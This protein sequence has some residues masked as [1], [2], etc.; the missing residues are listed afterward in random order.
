MPNRLWRVALARRRRP[1]PPW[2][3]GD[4]TTPQG[5]EEDR[6]G[7]SSRFPRRTATLVL[8]L[9]ANWCQL[10]SRWTWPWPG[11]RQTGEVGPV[12]CRGTRAGSD[13]GTSTLVCQTLA[14]S[15]DSLPATGR[16][17][18]SPAHG[19]HCLSGQRVTQALRG[20]DVKTPEPLFTFGRG[21]GVPVHSPPVEHV[22]G[23]LSPPSQP[24][25]YPTWWLGTLA[26]VVQT[27][28]EA[29]HGPETVGGLS[30]SS[31]LRKTGRSLHTTNP[32]PPLLTP[33]AGQFLGLKRPVVVNTHL[34]RSG[35][36]TAAGA[37]CPSERAGPPGG[38]RR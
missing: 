10:Q 31:R 1:E 27:W 21:H 5:V 11:C 38:G 18:K 29:A 32:P 17:A 9:W 28:N 24:A 6:R 2:K 20:P 33:H 3:F 13:L 4:H 15:E 22:G 8:Q 35:W 34:P 30:T 12:R 26:M 7:S 23:G 37:N 25:G 19:N 14:K 16:R 36:H